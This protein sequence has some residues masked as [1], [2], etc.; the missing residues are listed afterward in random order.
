[1]KV[2]M[3]PEAVT[4]RLRQTSELRRLCLALAGKRISG[5]AAKVNPESDRKNP[6]NHEAREIPGRE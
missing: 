3:S 6:K 5:A 4:R 1:M 2:D